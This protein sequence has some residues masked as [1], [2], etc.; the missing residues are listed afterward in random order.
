METLLGQDVD[1]SISEFNNPGNIEAG[2]GFDGEIEGEGYGPNKRFAKFRTPQLG[3]R[4]LKLDLTTKLRRFNGDLAAMIN[5][6]APPSENDTGQY[7]KVVQQY[8]GVKDRYTEADLD[9]IV[10]GFIRMENKKE[11]AEK[12][13]KLMEA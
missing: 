12:Y 5:Q 2:I 9:N 4:A 7:L 3:I 11:L 6:Y 13:I 8:A 10:K 1:T